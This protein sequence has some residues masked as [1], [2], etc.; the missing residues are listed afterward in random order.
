MRTSNLKS[1]HEQNHLRQRIVRHASIDRWANYFQGALICLNQFGI[2]A[3]LS[4]SVLQLISLAFHGA[5]SGAQK[6]VI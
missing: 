5:H 3:G 6:G 4:I 1:T 2:G